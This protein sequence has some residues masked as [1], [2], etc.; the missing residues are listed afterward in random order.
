MTKLYKT[1]LTVFVV[2]VG[3]ACSPHLDY[4]YYIS[5]VEGTLLRNGIPI[6]NAVITRTYQLGDYTESVTNTTITDNN[7]KFVIPEGKEYRLVLTIGEARIKQD[8]T[9]SIDEHQYV[10]WKYVKDNL[11]FHGEI[12]QPIILRCDTATNARTWELPSRLDYKENKYFGICEV[13]LDNA[14]E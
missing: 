11:Q 14:A 1:L 3:S 8:I 10:G 5:K 6:K 4:I 2:F 9:I 13:V 12:Y 7:G